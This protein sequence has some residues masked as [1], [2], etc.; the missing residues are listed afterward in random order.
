MKN[1]FYTIVAISV[2]SVVMLSYVHSFIYP[3][4]EGEKLERRVE[5]IYERLD[6]KLDTVLLHI[7]KN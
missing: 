5:A 4:V 2:S 6:T 1:F 3:R 7:Q